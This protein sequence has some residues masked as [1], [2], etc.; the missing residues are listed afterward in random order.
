MG[1]INVQYKLSVAQH[2]GSPLALC[3]YRQTNDQNIIGGASKSIFLMIQ[4]SMMLFVTSQWNVGEV[5][6]C[7][8]VWHSPLSFTS[9]VFGCGCWGHRRCSAEG[10]C[11]ISC[12]STHAG[13][14]LYQW[15]CCSMRTSHLQAFFFLPLHHHG[16]AGFVQLTGSKVLPRPLTTHWIWLWTGKKLN[17]T[18]IITEV[19]LCTTEADFIIL[20]GLKLCDCW[21]FIIQTSLL[22]WLERRTGDQTLISCSTLCVIVSLS[23]FVPELRQRAAFHCT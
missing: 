9:S 5:P 14:G 13:N 10:C 7:L 19:T 2:V 16:N 4:D 11:L 8:C 22:I 3:E 23:H 20:D 6:E 17:L 21:V 15:P 18:T 12:P 1:N